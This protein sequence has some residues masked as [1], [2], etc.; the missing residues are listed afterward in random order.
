MDGRTDRRVDGWMDE[1]VMDRQMNG[2]KV[3][4]IHQAEDCIWEN[5]LMGE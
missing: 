3:T 1:T 5:G 4:I 2:R